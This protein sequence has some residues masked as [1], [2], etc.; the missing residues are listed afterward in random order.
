MVLNLFKIYPKNNYSKNK[1]GSKGES[2]IGDNKKNYKTNDDAGENIN[3][4]LN[5]REKRFK[6]F[7]FIKSRISG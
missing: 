7:L 5:I 3:S 4:Y 1:A 2:D 6:N